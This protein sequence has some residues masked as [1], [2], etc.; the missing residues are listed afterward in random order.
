MVGP[1]EDELELEIDVTLLAE[2]QVVLRDPREADAFAVLDAD[3]LALELEGDLEVEPEE[4]WRGELRGGRSEA[5]Q[6]SDGAAWVVLL[7]GSRTVRAVPVTL[8]P[9]RPT[10]LEL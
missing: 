2:L 8:R 9:D 1:T 3:G 6:V 5:L 4:S 7:R 10:L